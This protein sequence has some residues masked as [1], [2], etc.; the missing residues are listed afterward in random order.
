[1]IIVICLPAPA[2]LEEAETINAGH[3]EKIIRYIKENLG[4]R[5]ILIDCCHQFDEI[6]L[7]A[8]E[9][10]D[11]LDAGDRRNPSRPC[12]TPR[13]CWKPLTSWN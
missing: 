1:M 13:K 7:K 10:S 6:T 3:L 12:P 8:L 5:W 4:F 11:I 2:R 9:L